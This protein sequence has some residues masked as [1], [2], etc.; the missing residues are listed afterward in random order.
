MQQER[1]LS[2]NGAK[3]HIIILI[4]EENTIIFRFL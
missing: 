3:L 1:C 4:N 2:Q